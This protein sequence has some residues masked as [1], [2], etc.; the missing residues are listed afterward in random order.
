MVKEEPNLRHGPQD[1]YHDQVFKNEIDDLINITQ[2]HY[3]Q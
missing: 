1:S 3:D 2:G